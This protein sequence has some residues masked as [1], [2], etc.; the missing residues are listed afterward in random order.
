MKNVV[1]ASLVVLFSTFS[2]AGSEPNPA[3][4][5][6][7]LHVSSSRIDNKYGGQALSVII[8]GKKC[9]LLSESP[10]GQLLGLGDYRARLVKD[11][12]KTAYDSLRV[13]EFLFPDQKTRKFDL[14]WQTE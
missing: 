11:E 14:V 13:Y 5:T 4:Y 10:I 7:N 2:W 9:E 8:D 3:E 1:L 12:H 6:T